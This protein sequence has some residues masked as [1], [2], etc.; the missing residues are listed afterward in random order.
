[1]IKNGK[2]FLL[3][4]INKFNFVLKHKIYYIMHINYFL[5][6]NKCFLTHKNTEELAIDDF[7]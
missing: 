4:K 7:L 3:I 5:T 2:K 6:H 1:M